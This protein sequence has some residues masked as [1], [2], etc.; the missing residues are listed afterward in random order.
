MHLLLQLAI[1]FNEILQYSIKIKPSIVM[2]IKLVV[3]D[4]IRNLH[5]RSEWNDID[6]KQSYGHVSKRII[7]ISSFHHQGAAL[8]TRGHHQGGS[9]SK[10]FHNGKMYAHAAHAKCHVCFQKYMIDPIFCTNQLSVCQ[11]GYQVSEPNY[12]ACKSDSKS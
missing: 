12:D 7:Q 9:I 4:V 8:A 11:I 5:F 10:K 3:E 6:Q 1:L 2:I